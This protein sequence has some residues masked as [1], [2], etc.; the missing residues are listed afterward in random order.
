MAMDVD[1]SRPARTARVEAPARETVRTWWRA[2]APAGAG[3]RPPSLAGWLHQGPAGPLSSLRGRVRR[4]RCGRHAG[5]RE[6]PVLRELR[7]PDRVRRDSPDVGPAPRDADRVAEP[8]RA[9]RVGDD[10]RRPAEL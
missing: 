1:A 8:R 5:R 10:G 9:R 6:Q 4:P 3:R 7:L 2:G